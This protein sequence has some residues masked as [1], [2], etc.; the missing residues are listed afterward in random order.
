[1]PRSN[2]ILNESNL[3]ARNGVARTPA[4]EPAND[5]RIAVRLLVQ[6]VIAYGPNEPQLSDYE[7]ELDPA[8][9]SLIGALAESAVRRENRRAIRTVE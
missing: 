8:I 3:G 5:N 2:L 1:M 7:N 9:V 4:P 6:P